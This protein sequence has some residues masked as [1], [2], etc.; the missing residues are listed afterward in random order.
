MTQTCL[1]R[2]KCLRGP[3]DHYEYDKMS[4]SIGVEVS[5]R[6]KIYKIQSHEGALNSLSKK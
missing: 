2:H 5:R 6:Q 3:K 1:C 4:V